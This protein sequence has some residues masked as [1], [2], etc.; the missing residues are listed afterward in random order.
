MYFI[1]I[2]NRTVLTVNIASPAFITLF[3]KLLSLSLTSLVI[4]LV[5]V[6]ARV[7]MIDATSRNTIDTLLFTAPPK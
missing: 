5:F 7:T 2:F 4:L 3:I 1:D 6:Q